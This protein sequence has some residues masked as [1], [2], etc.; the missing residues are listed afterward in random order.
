MIKYTQRQI[1]DLILYK[2]AE[3]ITYG[4]EA[5]RAIILKREGWLKSIGYSCGTYGCNGKVFQGH[6][7][8]KLYAIAGRTTA[9][10]L[11]E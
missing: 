5:D 8:G 9:L 3:D 11:F 7:T 10:Y 4:D 1:K 6:N 2:Y